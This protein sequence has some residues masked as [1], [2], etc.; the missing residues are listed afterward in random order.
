MLWRTRVRVGPGESKRFHT[1]NVFA[2]VISE[3]VVSPKKRFCEKKISIFLCE[4]N[5]GGK[6]P[7]V[8]DKLPV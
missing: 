1:R 8:L 7:E 4:V 6:T 5:F 2:K 3:K